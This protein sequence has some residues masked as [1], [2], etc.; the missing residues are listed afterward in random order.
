M[1][2]KVNNLNWTIEY[3]EADKIYMNKEDDIYLG[4]T[5]YVPQRISIRTEMSSELTREAVIHELTHCFLFS[6]G[7]EGGENFDEESACRFMG[8]HADGIV[9]LAD[10][11]MGEV[12]KC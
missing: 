5:E 1:E 4:R 9:K 12:K 8:A 10:K 3:V 11:F 6:Y 7:I 2:F